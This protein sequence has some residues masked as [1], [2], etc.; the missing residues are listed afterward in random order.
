MT[1]PI[2]MSPS[3]LTQSAYE[4]SQ[5]AGRVPVEVVLTADCLTPHG[6]ED[7]DEFLGRHRAKG[8]LADRFEVVPVQPD[9]ETH[10]QPSS[11]TDIRGSEEPLRIA[12]HQSLL[13]AR[14]GRA[15]QMR[16]LVIMMAVGPEHQE[17]LLDEEGRCAV[18][19]FLGDV[20]KSHT[21][22]PHPTFNVDAHRRKRRHSAPLPRT[23][24]RSDT[25]CHPVEAHRT[26][27]RTSEAICST[28]SG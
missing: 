5:R 13:D 27:G 14:R 15:P 8:V 22:R 26:A 2:S 24:R 23:R 3:L 1:G 21:D 9:V 6:I 7:G 4:P 17:L 28:I 10:A 16:K 12:G 20:R 19:R 25:A 18:A 11:T